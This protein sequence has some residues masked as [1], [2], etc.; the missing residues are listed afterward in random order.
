MSAGATGR[1][2]EVIA[3]ERWQILEPTNYHD[4]HA[5]PDRPEDHDRL[6]NPEVNALVNAD[7]ERIALSPRFVTRVAQLPMPALVVHGASDPRPGWSA[8]TVA[9]TMANGEFVSLP[10]VGHYPWV[11]KPEL[12]RAALR[13]FLHGM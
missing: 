12:L 1:E 3:R 5:M 8:E 9:R 11:E 2:R 13:A 7:H 4:P 6:I 10:E